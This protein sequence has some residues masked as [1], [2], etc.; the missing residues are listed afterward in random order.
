MRKG[1]GWGTEEWRAKAAEDFMLKQ[2][3]QV[4]PMVFFACGITSELLFWSGRAGAG[5]DD[6]CTVIVEPWAWVLDVDKDNAV[7]RT[8]LPLALGW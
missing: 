3:E 2:K 7:A 8:Q 1:G 5:A 4:L 6:A